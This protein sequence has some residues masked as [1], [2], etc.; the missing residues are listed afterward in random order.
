MISDEFLDRFSWKEKLRADTDIFNL[1][2]PG[3]VV[4]GV[5]AQAQYLPDFSCCEQ[6]CHGRASSWGYKRLRIGIPVFSDI[7]FAKEGDGL[8]LFVRRKAI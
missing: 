7:T 4:N 6:F 3:K 8:L 1:S 5:L 2:G